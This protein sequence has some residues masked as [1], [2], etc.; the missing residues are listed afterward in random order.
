MS[1]EIPMINAEENEALTKWRHFLHWRAGERKKIKR[2]YNKRA[3]KFA[4]FL[5]GEEG[6]YFD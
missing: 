3:R 2:G 4:K 1:R 6:E 5:I